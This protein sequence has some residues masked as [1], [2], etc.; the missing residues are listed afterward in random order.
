M[1]NPAAFPD[2]P[3][4]APDPVLFRGA[5]AGKRAL[6]TGHT[7]FKG[8]WLCEWLLR[9]GAQVTGFSLPPDGKPCLF[10]QLRLADRMDS[11]L[12]DIRGAAAIGRLIAETR[13]DFVF[14]LAAQPL[15]RRSYREPALTWHTNVIGTVN[16]LEA[17]RSAEHPCAAVLV[18]TDK[19]YENREWLHGYREVDPLGGRDPYS[20]SKAAAEL[21]IQAW[22]ASFFGSGNVRVASARAGNVIGGG[23]WSEDRIVPDC[24]RALLRGATVRVRNP[25]STRP[26]QHVLEPL[27]GYLW[28]AARMALANPRDEA[29]EA[30]F[31]FG[32]GYEGNRLVSEL[33]DE[34]VRL[35]GGA[36]TD[37]SQPGAAH[38]ATLL[39]LSID[40]A[41][42]LLGWRPLWS[43]D[44]TVRET[45]RWYFDV[46]ASTDPDL[47]RR[48]TL[49]QIQAYEGRALERRVAWASP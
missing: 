21:A 20:S 37:A 19:C 17:L 42:A 40:K 39:Q 23:D 6:V 29:L 2:S 34:I 8:A 22:R 30:P 45:M 25:R 31:N 9:L 26:W 46:H 38:E 35:V 5:F 36:W 1:V 16:V 41:A 32:P 48:L 3:R 43:F 14:H 44:E 24:A 13:P 4:N 49:D 18:T 12:G 47:P 10:Q 11:V 27:S 15:V 33:V 7:G 28:L